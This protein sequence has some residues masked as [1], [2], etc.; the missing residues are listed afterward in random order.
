MISQRLGYQC[1]TGNAAIAGAAVVSEYPPGMLPARH[2]FLARDRV[3]AALTR[4]TLVVEAARR[5]GTIVTACG[6]ASSAG[7]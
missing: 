3:I 1:V 6:P 4:G 2:R 5:G 7:W